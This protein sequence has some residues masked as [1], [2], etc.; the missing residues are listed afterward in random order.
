MCGAEA[1]GPEGSLSTAVLASTLKCKLRGQTRYSGAHGE[2]SLL[3]EMRLAQR[4]QAEQ[5]YRNCFSEAESCEWTWNVGP[6]VL[7]SYPDSKVPHQ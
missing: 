1:S 4:E 3:P 2:L 7:R 5:F 6:F